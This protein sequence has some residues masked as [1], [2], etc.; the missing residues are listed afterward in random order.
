METVQLGSMSWMELHLSW[1]VARCSSMEAAGTWCEVLKAQIWM[2]E[3]GWFLRHFTR[4]NWAQNV[5][6]NLTSLYFA[7]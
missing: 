7:L 2:S 6:F 5:H 1:Q 3:L 4:W